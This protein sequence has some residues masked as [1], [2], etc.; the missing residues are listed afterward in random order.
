MLYTF[1]KMFGNIFSCLFFRLRATGVENIPRRGAFI[2]AP[3]HRSYLDP[4][5]VAFRVPRKIYF[6]SKTTLYRKRI[7]LPLL[8]GLHAIPLRQ[9][10]GAVGLKSAIS[11][12]KKGLPVV[13]FPEGTRN[14]T[15]QKFLAGTKGISLL[16]ES[17]SV[18]V[19]PVYLSGTDQALPH[20]AIMFR[21]RAITVAYGKPLEF[22]GSPD[23]FAEKVMAEIIRLSEPSGERNG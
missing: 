17:A 3:N 14:R 20:N 7:F 16:A 18:P 10:R 22:G 2:L 19:V 11:S 4:P 9:G 23:A 5:L 21:P 6:V 1:L 13:I 8:N 15:R 12:L